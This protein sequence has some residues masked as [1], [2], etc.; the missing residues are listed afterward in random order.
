[1]AATAF[2]LVP[3]VFTGGWVWEETAARLRA[4]GAA[5]H[6]VTLTGLD[7]APGDTDLETHTADLLRLV[8]T[9]TERRIVLVAHGYGNHPATAAAHRRP[10]RIARVVHVDAGL[11]KDGV[12]ALAVL[13]DERTRELLLAATGEDAGPVPPPGPDGWG[14][15]GSTDGVPS[16]ALGLLTDRAA[17]HPAATLTQPLRLDSA[18]TGAPPATA[19]LCTAGGIGAGVL[20][21]L[22]DLGDPDVVA[23]AEAG[24]AFFELATGHWPMLS[25]PGELA[26]VL[27][28]AAAGEGRRL[29]PP[30]DREPPAHLRPFLLD[31]PGRARER[32]G[33]VDL[34][35]PDSRGEGGP[36]PA[37]LF[38]H[39][40][41]VPA[42]ARPTP[43]D[44]PAYT[45]Y[46][47]YAARLGAVGALVDHRLHGFAD[48]PRAAR[49][50][51]DA[52]AL[53]RADPRVDAGR[54]GLWFFS[55]GGLLAADWLAAP[56]PWLRCVAATYP[57][58]APLPGWPAVD[59]R[60]R[61][62][63]AVR[64]D[65]TPPLVLTRVGREDPAIAATVSAFLAA[66]RAAAA[67]V[68]V[69]DV[70]G[71]RHAFETLDD[72]EVAREAVRRAMRTVL[73]RLRG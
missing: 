53:L 43:R 15:W 63:E 29:T 1:M 12:P 39:G 54:I 72:R 44:W 37:V 52:V 27:L 6:P 56:P 26:E 62:A 18:A 23:L 17:P 55:G 10:G 48:Y 3:D 66:A 19:V 42:G 34:Y 35:P 13:P 36:R 64:G 59:R 70:P 22:L 65:G 41:P 71:A 47:R 5:A 46:A 7:G 24:T 51:A 45:G 33:A 25:A 20:E 68:E 58:L 31:V 61:P 32:H 69:I 4:A 14:R 8:D 57:V 60:F 67:P 11:P 9:L 40:G 16:R 2:V 30:A 38:V 49:D 21:G 50:V 73:E 28:R